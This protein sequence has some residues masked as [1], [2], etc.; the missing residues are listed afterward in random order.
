MHSLQGSLLIFLEHAF[1]PVTLLLSLLS[2]F[3]FF[4]AGGG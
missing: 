4:L 2:N 3:P 1:A